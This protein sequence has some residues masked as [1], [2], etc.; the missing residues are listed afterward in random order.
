LHFH[1]KEPNARVFCSTFHPL[2]W[3]DR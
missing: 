2:K 1:K 3:R